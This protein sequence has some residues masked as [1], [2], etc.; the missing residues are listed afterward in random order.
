MT[1]TSESLYSWL[2]GVEK[3]C[4]KGARGGVL[5]LEV[6]RGSMCGSM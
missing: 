6:G 5:G 1:R 3:G 4:R 2:L